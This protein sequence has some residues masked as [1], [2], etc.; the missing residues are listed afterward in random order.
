MRTKRGLSELDSVDAFAIED[1]KRNV[2]DIDYE[3]SSTDDIN[4]KHELL[5]KKS[6]LSWRLLRNER[7]N[8]W[9]DAAQKFRE[10]ML[11]HQE[12]IKLDEDDIEDGDDEDMP[13]VAEGNAATENEG[14]R[15][16][17]EDKDEANDTKRT[18]LVKENTNSD[19][20]ESH[21]TPQLQ[22]EPEAENQ[23]MNWMKLNRN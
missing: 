14:K 15:Q 7:S 1:T 12:E 10:E 18:K 6:L 3:L 19:L 5:E 22:Q 21:V 4:T 20:Q 23:R 8:N 17:E 2:E 9:F 16:L 11:S 13:D